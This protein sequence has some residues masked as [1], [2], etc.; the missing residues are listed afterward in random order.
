[1][2]NIIIWI[3]VSV[4]SINCIT[5]YKPT[6]ELSSQKNTLEK[7][8]KLKL[9][10]HIKPFPILKDGGSDELKKFFKNKFPLAE[11]E[12]MED[13][14][15]DKGYFCKVNTDWARFSLP[16]LLFAY[17]SFY[18]LTIIPAWS[19]E[20][21]YDIT[22][23]LY[24]D[25]AKIRDFNYS[26]RRRIFLWIFTLPVIWINMITDSEEDAFR[27]INNEFSYEVKEY[28]K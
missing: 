23:S 13:R 3:L 15:P 21:G 1:M 5:S 2:K 8:Y 10:Y 27:L 25:G 16:S 26:I 18:S 19:T 17:I 24:K 22:Y 20:D 12:E 7:N 9:F 6:S 14:I 11:T 28:L 4:L